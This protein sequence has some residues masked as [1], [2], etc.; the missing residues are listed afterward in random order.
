MGTQK[1]PVGF[2]RRPKLRRSRTG[3]GMNGFHQIT[4]YTVRVLVAMVS[5]RWAVPYLRARSRI[6]T[7]SAAPALR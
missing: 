6:R 1:P 3:I 4:R 5:L 7:R 2:E